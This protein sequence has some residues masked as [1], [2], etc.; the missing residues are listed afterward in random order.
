[1][2]RGRRE[3]KNMDQTRNFEITLARE[4]KV[5]EIAKRGCR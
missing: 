5:E 4:L 1:M 2:P 3:S